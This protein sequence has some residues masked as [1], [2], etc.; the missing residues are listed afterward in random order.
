V[1]SSGIDYVYIPLVS[2]VVV[3]LLGLVLRWS[4]QAQSRRGSSRVADPEHGLLI[5]VLS[6]SDVEAERVRRLLSQEGVRA[7]SRPQGSRRQ[8]LVWPDDVDIALRL[9]SAD[10]DRRR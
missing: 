8:V 9:V 7:T 6:A 3:G 5:G 2:A 1:G 10:R 4:M